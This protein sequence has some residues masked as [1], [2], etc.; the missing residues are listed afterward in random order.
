MNNSIEQIAENIL[1]RKTRTSRLVIGIDGFGASGKSTFAKMLHHHIPSAGMVC[2]DH[3]YQ[4]LVPGGTNEFHW[5]RFEKEVIQP[6]RAGMEIRYTP[7]DWTSG[8]FQE[9]N[10]ITKDQP[11]IVEGVYSTQKRFVDAYDVKIWVDVS[12]DT[13]LARG[14][15]RDGEASRPMWENTWLPYTEKY[16]MEFRPD[17]CADMVIDG[18]RSDFEKGLVVTKDFPEK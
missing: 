13:R 3:F 6:I 5:E 9:V 18:E 8:S 7:Y 17:L 12:R 4:P 14:I 16:M 1:E 10:I 11:V 2:I 15:A